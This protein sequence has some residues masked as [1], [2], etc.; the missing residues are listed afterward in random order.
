ML[1]FPSPPKKRGRGRPK[2]YS[3]RLIGKAL[4]IM[5]IRR[6]DTAYSL[7][8]FL[9]QDTFLTGQLRDLLTENGRFP[10][11]RTWER[12]LQSL[13]D[14]LPGLIGCFGRY[15]V[16]YDTCGRAAAMDRTMLPAK[17]GVWHKKHQEQGL[18]PHRIID[19]DAHW[20]KSGYHGWWYGW[21]LHITCTIASIWIPL[22]AELTPANLH[23]RT[24]AIPMAYELPDEGRYLMGDRHYR[25]DD[26]KAYCRLNEHT[27]ITTRPGQYPHQD[28]G[29]EVRKILHRLR[30]QAIEPFNGFFKNVFE[31]DGQVPVRGHN[32][33]PL[34]VYQLVLLYQFRHNK[35]LGKS[36]NALL[37]AA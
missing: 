31:G 7:L 4:V 35:P 34:F 8:A 12:R 28:A 2:D 30:H 9:E 36:V 27:L 5:I 16:A 13:P 15:L 18:A 22:A 32:P 33:V 6:L 17:G 24:I 20:S 37:R 19:T 29:V 26:L 25:N 14:S 23:D 10:S 3:D 21:K 11:R 1:P